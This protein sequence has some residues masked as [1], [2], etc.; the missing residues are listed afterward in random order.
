M[1]SCKNDRSGRRLPPLL[2]SSDL[3]RERENIKMIIANLDWVSVSFERRRALE[4]AGRVVLDN[5]GKGIE[6]FRTGQRVS[7]DGSPVGFLY[8][9]NNLPEK[10]NLCQLKLD[11]EYLYSNK[12]IANV[13][14]ALREDLGLSYVGLCRVDIC[15]DFQNE[16]LLIQGF[17]IDDFNNKVA[18]GRIRRT[19]LFQRA[20]TRVVYTQEEDLY[21]DINERPQIIMKNGRIQTIYFGKSNIRARLYNKSDELA[22]S[23]KSYIMEFWGNNGF[24]PDAEVWRMELEMSGLS[25]HLRNLH[26]DGY[27]LKAYYKWLDDT[28]FFTSLYF[29]LIRRNYSF[30]YSSRKGVPIVSPLFSAKSMAQ[31][32]ALSHNLYYG[33][34]KRPD[35]IEES[36]YYKGIKNTLRR[37]STLPGDELDKQ[38]KKSFSAAAAALELQFLKISRKIRAGDCTPTP[39]SNTGVS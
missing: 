29:Y 35:G 28:V 8:S 2:L 36:N 27:Q 5:T 11:N 38:Q 10:P 33:E 20:K 23:Q 15:G 16:R 32:L 6:T 30:I 13:I 37:L 14:D 19:K 24:D 1:L 21:K 25:S 22:V 4:S 9:D 7:I 31:G 18:A 26:F 3:D 34:A 12:S 39:V 17:S